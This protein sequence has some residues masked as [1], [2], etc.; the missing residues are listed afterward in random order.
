M[1]LS[2][3]NEA[4][5]ER[6]LEMGIVYLRHVLY[7]FCRINSN[8]FN[9]RSM[10]ES[11]WR[12]KIHPI[13]KEFQ[14]FLSLQFDIQVS[15]EHIAVYCG[16]TLINKCQLTKIHFPYTPIDHWKFQCSSQDKEDGEKSINTK[17]FLSR[18]LIQEPPQCATVK[19]H[20]LSCKWI[21]TNMN[22]CIINISTSKY[23]Q[24]FFLLGICILDQVQ[25]YQCEVWIESNN[26]RQSLLILGIITADYALV[27]LITFYTHLF[28]VSTNIGHH[29]ALL[30]V[31]RVTA[32]YFLSVNTNVK[33][34]NIKVKT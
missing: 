29:Q 13:C 1:W 22:T 3:W 27:I 23:T 32:L 30:H 2:I 17:V 9:I 20:L 16:A 8:F 12:H 7:E 11:M 21:F 18:P 15:L 28:H 10:M 34:K 4:Q 6:R 33:Y 26:N 5:E 14:H 24:Q 19:V 31:L 25:K